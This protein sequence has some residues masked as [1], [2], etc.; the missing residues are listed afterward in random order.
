MSEVVKYLRDHSF[1]DLKN[2]FGIKVKVYDTG[3]VTLNYD[4]IESPRFHQIVDECR[5]LI[6]HK[7]TK[8]IVSR[9]F[10]RFYNV[11]EGDQNK[12][13]QIDLN[14]YVV[15]EKADGSII[16]VYSHNDRWEISTRGTAYAE[17]ENNISGKTFRAMVLDCLGYSEEEFQCF[18]AKNL[19]SGFTYVFELIGPLNRVVTPYQKAELVLLGVVSNEDGSE[20]DTDTLSEIGTMLRDENKA[21]RNPKVYRISNQQEL[22]DVL[23]NLEGLQEGFVIH[24][25]NTGHRVKMKNIQY[26]KAHRL[27]GESGI[28]SKN[29]IAELVVMNETEEILAYFPEFTPIFDE[30]K[31]VYSR[32][33]NDAISVYNQYRDIESQKEFALAVKGHPLSS[34]MFEARAKNVCIAHAISN[35]KINFLVKTILANV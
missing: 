34:C 35:A 26:L 4:Q 31:N 22:D 6:L 24:N 25:P 13:D 17:S 23:K 29:D 32:L 19:H 8:E 28:P 15:Y 5:G 1:D 20:A 11:S 9:S 14:E 7:D 18:A 10:K 27:R 21:I 33:T 30:I 16:K 3:L 2:E 12:I